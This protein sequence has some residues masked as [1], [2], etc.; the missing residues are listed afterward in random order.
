MD[1]T[2]NF[3]RKNSNFAISVALVSQGISQLGFV[4]VPMTQELYYAQKDKKKAYLNGKEIH[5]SSTNDLDKAVI[6]CDWAWGLE[7]RLNVV[8]WLASIST[9]VRQIKC[10]GSAVADLASLANGR[11]DG[12]LHSGLKPWDVA[13][14]LLLI[15][16]A[17]GKVT[18]PEGKDWDVF[19][20]DLLTSNG[21]LHNK[22]LNLIKEK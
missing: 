8:R 3:S 15:E 19:Q 18:T 10:M 9:H 20:P 17:G 2:V 16:K 22:I 14:S 11:I 7:K 12:Y 13:A 4:Y 6:G 5:V 21:L 1:G